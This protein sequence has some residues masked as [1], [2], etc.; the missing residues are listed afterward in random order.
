V[1]SQRTHNA[2]LAG[3]LGLAL[4][5]ATIPNI[6]AQQLEA[7]RP[8]VPTPLSED[9]TNKIGARLVVPGIITLAHR[10]VLTASQDAAASAIA[11]FE[12]TAL[13]RAVQSY[14]EGDLDGAKRGARAVAR[15]LEG[16][17]SPK[18]QAIRSQA[19]LLLANCEIQQ[20]EWDAARRHL[21]M[22]PRD[23]PVDD[24]VSWMKGDVFM[25]LE[26]FDEAAD[27]YKAAAS[28]NTAI[29]HRA[30]ARRAHA[31]FRAEKWK[32]SYDALNTLVRDF[33]DYP[34][35]PRALFERAVALEKLERHGEAANAFLEAWYAYPFHRFGK[36]SRLQLADYKDRGIVP[37]KTYSTE[38]LMSQYRTM[39]ID[40]HWDD[41]RELLAELAEVEKTESGTSSIENRIEFEQALNDYGQRHFESA[42][43]R[44]LLLA[45]RWEKGERE[46]LNRASI[47]R[48]LSRTYASMGQLDDALKALD[49]VHSSSALRTRLSARAQLLEAHGRYQEAFEIYDR[50]VA[51]G[52]RRTW[53]FT[54]L[55]YK[56]GQYDAAYENLAAM[57]ERSSGERQAKYLYWAAR[58]LENA[59]KERE[60]RKVFERVQNDHRTRYYGLQASNRILDID[61]RLSVSGALVA[62]AED[63]ANAADLALDALDTAHAY[64]AL[65]SSHEDPRTLLRGY[66][67]ETQA[68]EELLC[69]VDGL[70]DRCE[71][72]PGDIPQRALEVLSAA[73]SPTSQIGNI[74][75]LGAEFTERD[76]DSDGSGSGPASIGVLP[77][78]K[79]QN[80]QN[81]AQYSTSARIYWDGRL[82]SSTSFARAREGKIPGPTPKRA[83]AYD[84]DGYIGGLKRASEAAGDVFPQIERAHW[85]WNGGL[86][87]AARWAVRDVAIEYRELT[88][89]Y[90]P[91]RAPHDLNS[92]RWS[93]YIDNRR[94]DRAQFWGL[95]SD[96]R[97]FPIPSSAEGKRQ[98]VERQQQI[99]DRRNEL[100]PV[101]MDAFKEA[102][103]HFMVRRYTLG[104]GGWYRN[105][106]TGPMRGSWMQAYSRAFPSIVMREAKRY[107]LNPYVLWAL[108]TVESS[109]NPDSISPALALGLLQVIPK[110]GLKTAMML[111]DDDFGP[112]DLLDEEVAI[113]HGAFYF[114]ELIK[115]FHGQELLAFAGYN[116][117]PHRVGDWLDSRG[118][119]SLDEFIEEIPF[120]E[121]RGYSK[122]VARFISLYLRI[123]EGKDQLYIGQNVRADY[124][125][126]PRF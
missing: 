40:K 23:T 71:A 56:T 66:E 45:D 59:G 35:R 22:I 1:G 43:D 80:T 46:G 41:V 99:Y 117:G 12:D 15:Q 67:S 94:K 109:F 47:Y 98:L 9:A 123:Y 57:A 104:T 49:V 95:K 91:S 76:A 125:P 48:F 58:T 33:P 108:M 77:K 81:R 64:L 74:L 4:F 32:E 120:N 3:M 54:W 126:E 44:F 75:G 51:P 111:G 78:Q 73:V 112:L 26:R 72:N 82:G 114:S 88:R 50:L 79:L 101:L 13:D 11:S 53:D 21:D 105:D 24:I 110:T 124:R 85:L 18:M 30:N 8:S 90:R 84:E 6:A 93:Y 119:Q 87:T 70:V 14:Y 2:T 121:A 29:L 28:K 83:Y 106:P 20:S 39:R 31:L 122:K 19:L 89:R 55:L 27:W 100:R 63:V 65:A 42:R 92:L 17:K 61:Q 62:Q 115:K 52:Q 86:D 36:E 5:A 118:N 116:G 37:T 38:Q 107:G 60:A 34:R 10:D 16:H 96:E 7:E 68:P 97:R 25:A 102:G 69:T 103:D 113:R